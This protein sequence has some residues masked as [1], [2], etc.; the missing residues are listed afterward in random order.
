M[1]VRWP[2]I[3]STARRVLPV[4]VG[5][6]TAVTRPFLQYPLGADALYA[7]ALYADEL[8]KESFL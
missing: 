5:P 6:R 2:S 7:D 1:P 3:R 4:L 8:Y